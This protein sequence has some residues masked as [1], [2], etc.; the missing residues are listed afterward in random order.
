GGGVTGDRWGFVAAT[1]LRGLPHVQL[2]NMVLAMIESSGG[3][4]TGVDTPAGK[5]LIGA[6]H[7]PREVIADT[8]TLGTLAPEQIASGLAEAVKHG[9]I[10][11]A[12]YFEWLATA[13]DAIF[14]L[15]PEALTE[16][17]RR[18]VSIKAE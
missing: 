5:N 17:I 8:D 4:K 3:G 12:D 2:P 6:F 18:S 16:L 13:G 15:R 1:D 7:Q 10:A 9:A 11:D 14:A